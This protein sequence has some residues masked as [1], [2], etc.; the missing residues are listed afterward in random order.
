MLDSVLIQIRGSVWDLLEYPETSRSAQLLSFISISM[1]FISTGG[2]ECVNQFGNSTEQ[3]HQTVL[4][5]SGIFLIEASTEHDQEEVL[6]MLHV[7]DN[8]AIAYHMI[9]WV[10]I[11]Q[12]CQSTPMGLFTF[13]ISRYFLR[14]LVCPNKKNFITDK[15]N[16][17]DL[18]GILPAI[19][20]IILAGLENMKIIGQAR[21]WPWSTNFPPGEPDRED[22]EGDAILAHLQDDSTFR[23]PPKSFLHTPPGGLLESQ[24]H[25]SIKGFGFESSCAGLAWAWLD[26]AHRDHHNP[27]LLQPHIQFWAR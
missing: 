15:M 8:I 27:C 24:F 21:D 23:R 7:I 20:N 4:L 22:C 19:F 17:V 11:S 13:L 2:S 12:T 16:L 1:V 3:N 5:C 6:V 26:P 14:L 10:S 18:V 25:P 9:E